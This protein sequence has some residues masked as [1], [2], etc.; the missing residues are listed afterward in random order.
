MGEKEPGRFRLAVRA[1]D[2][3]ALADDSFW[4]HA[5]ASLDADA[6]AGARPDRGGI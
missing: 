4:R 1:I 2:P 6:E 3:S 5:A